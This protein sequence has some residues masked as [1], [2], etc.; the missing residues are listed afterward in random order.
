M[1][2]KKP[3]KN[4]TLEFSMF[5]IYQLTAVDVAYKLIFI[6][7]LSKPRYKTWMMRKP[8]LGLI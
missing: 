6:K 5:F 1:N 8:F 4:V 3:G 2:V 7:H